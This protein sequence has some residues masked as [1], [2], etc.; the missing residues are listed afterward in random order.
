MESLIYLSPVCATPEIAGGISWGLQLS[1]GINGWGMF[2]ETDEY[3]YLG[4]APNGSNEYDNGLDVPEPPI[5]TAGN[6]I[7]LYFKHPEWGS[8]FGN[9][10]TQDVRL[11]DDE[12]F[13]KNLVVYEAEVLSNMSGMAYIEISHLLL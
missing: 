10:F 11:E 4:V 1:A 12:Y 9:N 7:T 3:N 6:Y 13:Q 2:D 5:N 8:V